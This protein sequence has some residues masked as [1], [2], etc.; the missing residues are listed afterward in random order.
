M[1]ARVFVR[2]RELRRHVDREPDKRHDYEWQIMSQLEALFRALPGDVVAAGI[3]SSVTAGD[4][5]DIKVASDLLSG[6]ARSDEGPLEIA[7][8]DVKGRLRDYLKGSVDLVLRQDDFNGEEKANLASALAQVGEPGDTPD[9]VRLI[10]GDI[11]R[12]QRGVAV[13]A[14]GDRGPQGNGAITSYSPWHIA[15][16][17]QLGGVAAEQVLVDLLQQPDYAS[18]AATAMARDYLPKPGQAF[19]RTFRH[20]L[21]WAAREGRISAPAGDERRTRYGAAL[22]AEINRRRQL[23]EGGKPHGGLSVLAKALAAVDG[24]ASSQTVLDVIATPD[25]WDEY[26]CLDAAERLLTAGAVLPAHVAFALV[27]AVV[28]R[29]ETWMQHSDKYLLRRALALCPFVDDPPAGVAKVGAV[30]AKKRLYGHEL[31]ELV[32]SLGESRSD[33]AVELLRQLASDPPTFERCEDEFINAFA[34]LDTPSARAFLV[35]LVDID[36]PTGVALKQRP[37]RQDVL[38]ARLTELANRDPAVDARLRALCERDL[39]DLNRHILSGVMD[40]LGTPESL[41]A[42]L[43]L[44]DDRKPSPVPQG[45]WDQLESA[46]VERRPHGDGANLFSQHAR[47]SNDFRTRLFRMVTEDPNRRRSGFRLLGQIEEWRL[48]YGRP[49]GEPRHPDLASGQPWPP[50]EPGLPATAQSL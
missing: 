5:L 15:A 24:A 42:N 26:T 35:G 21:M 38:V 10:S 6:V 41:D 46:F 14:A 48:H 13:V 9:L 3:L 29:T 36:A 18:D 7:D 22:I 11:E 27:D 28:A 16:V 49:S 20:D 33:A 31:Q 12:R 4:S 32:T 1:A 37:F 25:Q 43:A 40:R 39:P 47:A 30:L 44:I 17:T 34:A 2:I 8:P 19:D 23:N 50:K 45:V